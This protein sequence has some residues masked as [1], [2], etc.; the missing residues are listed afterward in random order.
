MN[1][2]WK[3]AAAIL[4]CVI[5]TI[6]LE[7]RESNIALLLSVTTCCMVGVISISF[8]EPVMDLLFQLEVLANLED[9]TLKILI[10]ILGISFVA[11]IVCMICA[12]SGNSSLG[13]ILGFLSSCVILWLAIPIVNQFL[14]LLKYILGVI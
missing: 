8:L 4:I 7:K 5:L 10:K 9:N 11:E 13:K 6:T 2:F 1:L 12:D 14:D 3:S